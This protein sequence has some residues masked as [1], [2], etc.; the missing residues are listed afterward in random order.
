MAHGTS[1]CEFAWGAGF[2]ERWTSAGRAQKYHPRHWV[3][4][5]WARL[6]Q[7]RWAWHW[8]SNPEGLESFENLVTSAD[9]IG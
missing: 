1:I 4:G 8:A 6:A 7:G 5:P 2:A 3:I 9:L